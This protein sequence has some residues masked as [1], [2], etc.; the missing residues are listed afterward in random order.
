MHLSAPA[1]TISL[2]EKTVE[3]VE[4]EEERNWS[5]SS[6]NLCHFQFFTFAFSLLHYPHIDIWLLYI[7]GFSHNKRLS[8]HS[9]S[10]FF[11]LFI[12]D[13]IHYLRWSDI[14]WDGN[15]IQWNFFFI[16]DCLICFHFPD[17]RRLGPE[18]SSFFAV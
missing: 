14:Y 5:K 2:R 18:S 15:W 4:E 7:G 12:K 10:F 13:L 6:V 16:L 3:L 11:A 9:Y 1:A 17:F 8:I